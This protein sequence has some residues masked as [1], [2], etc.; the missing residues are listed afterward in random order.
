MA[1][2]RYVIALSTLLGAQA[3]ATDWQVVKQKNNIVI[4][5][6]NHANGFVKIK[7]STSLTSCIHAF[8]QLLHNTD[9]APNW[10]AH[11]QSVVVLA[12]PSNHENYVHTQFSSP[13]PVRDRDM[14]T[15]SITDK[16]NPMRMQIG[17][18]S[19]SDYIAPLSG[20]ERIEF[21]EASWVV[22]QKG[23]T[24]VIEHQAI[25]DPGGNIPKWL[26]NSMA[27]KSAY[28]TF[29]AMRNEL[30]NISCSKKVD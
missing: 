13:W 11:V 15:Y 6:Q 18:R 26:A 21:V 16:S 29:L 8:E 9:N 28:Q 23:Q 22:E 1:V 5:E 14:V 19:A 12:T 7:A 2:I 20:V 3:F 25:A 17:I 4:A 30:A 24:L 10:L 27:R